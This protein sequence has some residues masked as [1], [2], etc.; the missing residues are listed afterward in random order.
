MGVRPQTRDIVVVGGGLVGLTAASLL[1]DAGFTLTL[2]D[3]VTPLPVRDE[4]YDLRSYALTP[5]AQRILAQIGVW[6]RLAGSRI[7]EFTH[8]Q[9]W[10]AE[11][12]GELRF[13][14]RLTAAP[15]PLG[16]MVEHSNL[17]AASHAAVQARANVA[18]LAGQVTAVV[19]HPEFCTVHLSDGREVNASVLLACDGGDSPLRK[20]CGIACDSHAYA[21]TAVIANVTTGIPHGPIARQRF[22]RE[23]PL[24]L[25]PL[26]PPTLTAIVWTTTPA[27]AAW[28][29]TCAEAEFCAALA[30]AS[31]ARLGTID[32]TS[33]RLA[34]PLQRRH[35]AQYVRERVALLG[36]AAHVIHP[37]AGQGLNLGLLDVA[38]LAELLATASRARLQYPQ[39]LLKRYARIRRGETLAM[40]A[41]TEQLNR[42]FAIHNP[43]FTW[44]RNTGLN[45]VDKLTPLKRVLAQHAMGQG[46]EVPAIAR[47]LI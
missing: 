20:L 36:D 46:G 24:A 21:Q 15:A 14:V 6:P 44:L 28:L 5:A 18:G 32:G 7:A 45:L 3:P 41:V 19:N 22:L 17:L 23:G 35:A 10:D 9:V 16:Y 2:I 31:A 40:I 26:P 1:A 47:E 34:F 43:G 13:D 42:M 30:S 38:T 11:G 37:L 12:R 39:S 27:H 25:L 8:L 4:P 33:R 29:T